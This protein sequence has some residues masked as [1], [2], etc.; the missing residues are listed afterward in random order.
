MNMYNKSLIY[1]HVLLFQP[2]N[3]N[4]LSKMVFK[5]HK[6]IIVYYDLRT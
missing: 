4:K 2:N 5:L 6:I 1:M 3:G